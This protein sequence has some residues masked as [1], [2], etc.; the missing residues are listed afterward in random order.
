MIVFNDSNYTSS[1]AH[2]SL[3]TIPNSQTSS[4][5]RLPRGRLAFAGRCSI[6]RTRWEAKTGAKPPDPLAPTR[7][8][9]ARWRNLPDWDT[10]LQGLQ[11]ELSFDGDSMAF[12]LDSPMREEEYVPG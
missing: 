3:G 5:G 10:D 2:S 4:T 1:A 7:T 6:G 12:T 8:M 11:C 9:A